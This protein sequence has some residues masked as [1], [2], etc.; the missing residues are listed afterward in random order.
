MGL[1][2][3]HLSRGL[4][5]PTAQLEVG[6]HVVL[7]KRA[8]WSRQ[9]VARGGTLVVTEGRILFQPN[10]MESSIGLLPATWDRPQIEKV[11]VAPRGWNLLAGAPRRR[12]R[13]TFTD[14]T[15]ALFVVDDPD[16]VSVALA[17]EM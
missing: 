1:W 10:S 5:W 6:E 3:Q 15:Q 8:N 11:D 17:T 4:S 12:L 16:S 9:G 2:R 14:G 7:E 13:F